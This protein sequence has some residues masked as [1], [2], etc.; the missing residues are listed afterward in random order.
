[1]FQP[2]IN[3]AFII[4]SEITILNFFSDAYL[5]QIIRIEIEVKTIITVQIIAIIEFEGVH[6]GKLI[7]LYHDLPVSAK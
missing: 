3:N 1:M 6:A 5:F 2:T 4:N 7:E